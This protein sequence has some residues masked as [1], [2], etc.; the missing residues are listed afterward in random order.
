MEK[1]QK[2]THRFTFNKMIS[3]W[4]SLTIKNNFFLIWSKNV[5]KVPTLYWIQFLSPFLFPCN[6]CV[7]PSNL[8]SLF[9][10]YFLYFNIAEIWNPRQ[11]YL[12]NLSLL[13]AHMN[14]KNTTLYKP[15]ILFLSILLF[16]V[17]ITLILKVWYKNSCNKIILIKLYF[18]T[19]LQ[20]L[21]LQLINHQTSNLSSK[22]SM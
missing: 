4:K 18:Q 10:L 13:S 21:C 3:F 12:T 22:Y 1:L 15:I 6:N 20:K 9:P 11:Q 14:T 19:T 2:W 16:F 5:F 7:N 8:F 17:S